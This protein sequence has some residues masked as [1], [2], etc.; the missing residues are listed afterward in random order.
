MKK[1]KLKFQIHIFIFLFFNYEGAW[2]GKENS[3]HTATL[4]FLFKEMSFPNVLGND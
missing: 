2:G 1:V 4:T 3:L